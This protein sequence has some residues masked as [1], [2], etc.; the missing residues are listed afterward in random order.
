MS[1]YRCAAETRP[2]QKFCLACGAQLATCGACGASL[3]ADARFCAECGAEQ[4]PAEAHDDDAPARGDTAATPATARSEQRLVSVLF[5]DLVEFTPLAESLDPEAVEELLGRYFAT[6]REAITRRGGVIEKFIGDAVMAVWGAPVAYE[7]DAER[8]VL[9]ALDLVDAVSRL[10]SPDAARPIL[11]RAAVATGE[12]A[13]TFGAD[14]RGMVAGDVVNTAAR[15]QAAA[16]VGSVL[17]ADATYRAA[18]RSIAFEEAGAA[19]LKGKRRAVRTWRAVGVRSLDEAPSGVL[20]EAP[21]VGRE[22][23]MRLLG[24]LVATTVDAGGTH[25]VSVVGAAG[26][27]KTRLAG[28]LERVVGRVRQDVVWHRGRSPA[29]GRGTSYAAL[30]EMVRRAIGIGLE[31]PAA[32]TLGVLASFLDERQVDRAA[33]TWIEPRVAA[34]LGAGDA[35]PGER[36]ELHAAWRTFLEIAD[37]ERPGVM[38][39]EDVQWAD[40]GELEYVHHAL[41]WSRSR[42]MLV[43]TLARPESDRPRGSRAGGAATF[44]G[45]EPLGDAAA[46]QIVGALAP[47]LDDDTLGAIVSRAEGVPL[48]AIEMLRMLIE[49]GRVVRDDGR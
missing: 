6:A 47:G 37:A 31:R 11:I 24:D 45:L 40:A 22:R 46:R 36:D 12:V 10:E 1:C 21:F 20:G 39:F 44:L 34:L 23:E 25:L 41:D 29:Q 9:A 30:A 38:V 26:I 27:G 49:Q 13:A 43:I 8:A 7:D 19:Q 3:P 48:Y 32:E 5:A 17:V 18:S 4:R 28:E 14:D 42:S 35:P 15:L 2:G 33:R 16:S